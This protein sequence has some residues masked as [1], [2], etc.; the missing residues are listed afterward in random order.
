MSLENR[1]QITLNVSG[2]FRTYAWINLTHN[3]QNYKQKKKNWFLA[4]VGS[5][6]LRKITL[7]SKA[8]VY[9]FPL[10]HRVK[11]LETNAAAHSEGL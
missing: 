7:N 4:F 11:I 6:S 9:F 2:V 1:V 10:K 3:H 5:R 8:A